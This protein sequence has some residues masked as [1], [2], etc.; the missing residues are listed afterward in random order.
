LGFIKIKITKV[1][2]M[3]IILWAFPRRGRGVGK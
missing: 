1:E 3:Y 2:K